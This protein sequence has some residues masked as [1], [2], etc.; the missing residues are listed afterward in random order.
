ML[1]EKEDLENAHKTLI[2]V[3]Y[4]AAGVRAGFLIKFLFISILNL[5]SNSFKDFYFITL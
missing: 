1:I 3:R 5:L 2:E 4:L